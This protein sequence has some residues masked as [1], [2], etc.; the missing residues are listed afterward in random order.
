ML[1]NLSLAAMLAVSILLDQSE[2]GF[3]LLLLSSFVIGIGSNINEVTQYAMIN[4]LSAEVVS[5]YTVGTAVSGLFITTIR[6]VILAVTGSENNGYVPAVIYFA[7]AIGVNICAIAMNIYFCKSE[8][9]RDKIDAFLVR[10]SQSF[11]EPNQTIDPVGIMSA[12]S[13][14]NKSITADYVKEEERIESQS[15]MRTMK[16]TFFNVFPFP[17]IL[18]ANYIVTFTL[19]PGP[20]LKKTIPFMDTSWSVVIF[21]L[22]YNIGD[23]VGKYMAEVEGIFNKKSLIYAFF[24]RLVFYLPIIVMA[25]SSDSSD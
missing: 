23:T 24:G 22:S 15:Y 25:N 7:V 19:F 20:T 8:V 5:K 11:Y 17:L 18:I 3:I 16:E 2:V 6:A 4:Y 14:R 13:S 12:N 9:Y 21:L 1:V 10:H